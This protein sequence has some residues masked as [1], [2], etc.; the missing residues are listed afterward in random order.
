[1]Y[2]KIRVQWTYNDIHNNQNIKVNA[3]GSRMYNYIQYRNSNL[4][5][6]FS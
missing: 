3:F 1:M 6:Y 4:H 5:K 2:I